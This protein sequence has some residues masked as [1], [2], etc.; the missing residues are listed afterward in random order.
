MVEVK[1]GFLGFGNVGTGAYKIISENGNSIKKS[2]GFSLKVEKILVRN[3]KKKRDI[4]ID[5]A[6]I[7]EN[8]EDIINNP[9]ISIVAEFIAGVFGKYGVSIASVIQKGR[10]KGVAPLIFVT[11]PSKEQSVMKAIADIAKENDVIKVENVI[12]VEGR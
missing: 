1:L 8:I 5:E 11:H 3:S 4:E 12:H 9:K 7:T 6:L 2:E 10:G